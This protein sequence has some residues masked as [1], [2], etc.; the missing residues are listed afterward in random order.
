MNRSGFL[1]SA[2]P[3]ASRIELLPGS[4]ARNS[5]ACLAPSIR[6]NTRFMSFGT[7]LGGLFS[8]CSVLGEDITS[9]VTPF[10]NLIGELIE[11]ALLAR[12]K[13]RWVG[14]CSFFWPPPA[15]VVSALMAFQAAI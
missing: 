13:V 2:R 6:S 10:G 5:T 15:A 1:A 7:S 9:T 4:K 14:D 3:A 12:L 8:V 11:L